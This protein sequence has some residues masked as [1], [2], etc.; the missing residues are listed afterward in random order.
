M[1]APNTPFSTRLSGSA[2][3]TELRIRSIFQW[4]KKRP[5]VVVF[6][7][8]LVLV[9]GCFSLVNFMPGNAGAAGKMALKLIEDREIVPEPYLDLLDDET[10]QMAEEYNEV[11]AYLSD[12]FD[13][14]AVRM[15]D[16]F[17]NPQKSSALEA[18]FFQYGTYVKRPFYYYFIER[19]SSAALYPNAR[20]R[21]I[22]NPLIGTFIDTGGS[23]GLWATMIHADFNVGD[24]N[25]VLI[26]DYFA[27]IDVLTLR[28]STD[29][30]VVY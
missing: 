25:A 18:S 15:A 19:V 10:R 3:E 30:R 23:Y 20:E 21:L 2:K 27:L 16:F 14:Y 28:L 4:N 1:Q 17:S 26:Q 7:L 12:F 5:P 6:A 8:A 9:I 11:T 29:T 22:R 13:D 24:E